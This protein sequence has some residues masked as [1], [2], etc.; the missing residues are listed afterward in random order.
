V[1]FFFSG[2]SQ[3]SRH[4]QRTSATGPGDGAPCSRSLYRSPRSHGLPAVS[5]SNILAYI[6]MFFVVNCILKA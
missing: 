2:T 1:T 4:P 3:S 5:K 6:V